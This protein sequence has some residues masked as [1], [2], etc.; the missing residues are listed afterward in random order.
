PL[1]SLVGYLRGRELLLVLD[2]FEHVIPAAPV[3]ATLLESAPR[4][5][6]LVTS[7]ELLRL[8]GEHELRV[9]P[10]AP[11]AEGVALLVERASAVLQAFALR[12]DNEAAVIEICRRLDGVPLAIE[13]AAPQLRLLPPEQLLDRLDERF[14]GPRDLPERQRTLEAAIA[15][16]YEL[17]EPDE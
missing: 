11:E 6:I 4:L 5:R 12:E 3:V 15:W 8:R 1:E 16:S 10:L 13:L 2:N 9:P 14:A 7:R 17:L